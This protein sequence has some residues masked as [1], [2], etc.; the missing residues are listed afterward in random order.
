MSSKSA[1]QSYNLGSLL[2]RCCHCR[3]LTSYMTRHSSDG[4]VSSAAAER[5]LLTAVTCDLHH[6]RALLHPVPVS[7]LGPAPSPSKAVTSHA[8]FPRSSIALTTVLRLSPPELQIDDSLEHALRGGG[9]GPHE[10][11]QA[12]GI[13]ADGVRTRVIK[14][15]AL[16]RTRRHRVGRHPQSSGPFLA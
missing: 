3:L 6:V 14:P 2:A 4:F 11:E 13:C 5:L 9:G 12:Y 8:L 1:L 10:E 16:S 7:R 15:E